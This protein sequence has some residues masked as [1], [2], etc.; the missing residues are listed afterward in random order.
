MKLIVLLG[1]MME[2]GKIN[3]REKGAKRKCEADSKEH[4][5]LQNKAGS[6]RGHLWV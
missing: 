5:Q 4:G 1:K 3:I 2:R 6:L